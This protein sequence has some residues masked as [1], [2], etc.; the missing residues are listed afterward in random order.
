MVWLGIGIGIGIIV[1]FA[2]F[3]WVAA[4]LFVDPTDRRRDPR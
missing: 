2:L 3:I 1:L 4:L